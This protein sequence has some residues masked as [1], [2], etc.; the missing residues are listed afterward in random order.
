M[1]RLRPKWCW[2]AEIK[3]QIFSYRFGSVPAS[4]IRQPLPVERDK[5]SYSS[6]V[7]TVKGGL[8]EMAFLVFPWSLRQLLLVSHCLPRCLFPFLVSYYEEEWH[9]YHWSRR[10]LPRLRPGHG[11]DCLGHLASLIFMMGIRT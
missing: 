7:Q 9:Y 2:A 8:I 4:L 3:I 10:T 6:L 5:V 1:R 11:T